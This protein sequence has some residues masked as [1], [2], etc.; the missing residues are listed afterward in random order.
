M[1]LVTIKKWMA[2]RTRETCL[3]EFR[4]IQDSSRQAPFV[5]HRYKQA[6]QRHR[7]DLHARQILLHE[8]HSLRPT[9]VSKPV[10][11]RQW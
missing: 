4:K 7:Y 10:T 1:M 8:L 2:E 11:E 6:S 9:K 5:F 3:Q